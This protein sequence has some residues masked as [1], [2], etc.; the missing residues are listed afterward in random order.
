MDSRERYLRA[1]QFDRPDRVPIMHCTL[2]GAWRA[3]GQALEDLYARYP[4]DVLLSGRTRGPFA[5]AGSERGHW[6]GGAVTRD[7]WGCGWRWSTPDYMG[8]AVEHP[9]ADWRAWRD[10]RAPDPLTG[11]EG[12]AEMVREVDADG[13]RH[14]VFVDGG[15]VFQ[16]MI[17]LRGMEALLIDLQE[18]REEVYALR[19]RIV[20]I[21]LRRIERWLATGRVDGVI[22][23]DDW[24]TQTALMIRPELWR[25]VFRPAYA[26]L[27]AAIHAGGAAASFHTDGMI[28]AIVPDLIE[29]GCDEINPQ[30][31]VMDIEALGALCRGRVCVRAD[32]DRQFTLPHGTPEDVRRLVRRLFAAFGTAGGGYVGWAE[33]SSDVP[34]A[35]GE[36]ALETLF[37]LRYA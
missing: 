31:H 32:L 29:I 7:D 27:V 4:G 28:A 20:E 3:H 18:E 14:F 23:R 8:Q 1:L 26:R 21:C 30:V 12:V 34:L 9:L 22:L 24:G 35:N 13:H 33:M 5:L 19:D 11:S 36:A 6:A 2:R 25:R 17:F 16:R 37:G 15:E 10:Y